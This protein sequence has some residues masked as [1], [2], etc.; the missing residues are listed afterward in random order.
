[1]AYSTEDMDRMKDDPVLRRQ[2]V[3]QVGQKALLRSIRLREAGKLTEAQ[4]EAT[5]GR[6]VLDHIDWIAKD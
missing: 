6:Y 1:M 5:Y 4:V 3:W 2:Y